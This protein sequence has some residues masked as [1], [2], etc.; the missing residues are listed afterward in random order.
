[1]QWRR[2][3]STHRRP[4]PA[5]RHPPP[6][7]RH[8][9]DRGSRRVAIVCG[10]VGDEPD[11]NGLRL[12]AYRQAPGRAGLPLDPALVQHVDRLT[13]HDAAQR[14][15]D[16]AHDGLDFGGVFCATGTVAMGVPRGLADSGVRVPGEVRLIGFD[17]VETS[18]HLAPLAVHDRPGRRRDGTVRGRPPG[19]AVASSVKDREGIV[20]RFTPV[21]RES[22]GR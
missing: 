20:S 15:R 19:P 5:T 4:P 9:V 18:A 14:A 10:A 7:T 2:G 17:N 8:L 12:A 16:T 13:V 1:M 22:T 3:T 11:G 6:A 21:A